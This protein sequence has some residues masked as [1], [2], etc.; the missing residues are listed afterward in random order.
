MRTFFIAASICVIAVYSAYESEVNFDPAREARIN[1]EVDE[2][3]IRG[4]AQES[5]GSQY[6][7]LANNLTHNLNDWCDRDMKYE[8]Y[9]RQARSVV[10]DVNSA[11]VYNTHDHSD[12]NLAVLI[13]VISGWVAVRQLTNRNNP[14]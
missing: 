4:I 2:N 5:L 1:R 13:A 14:P 7:C 12:R 11:G 9:L 3:S 8:D 6:Q 10:Q